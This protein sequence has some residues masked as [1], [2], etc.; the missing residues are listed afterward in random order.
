M[1]Y[2]MSGCIQGHGMVSSN[3]YF[4]SRRERVLIHVEVVRHEEEGISTVLYRRLQLHTLIRN[5]V[6]LDMSPVAGGLE[7]ADLDDFLRWHQEEGTVQKG[8]PFWT[9]LR[10]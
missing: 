1:P 9:R 2:T 6:I 7:M 5:N 10:K 3:D 8:Q 4:W